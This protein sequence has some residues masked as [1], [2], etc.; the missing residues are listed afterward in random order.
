MR[1]KEYLAE[2]ER[3]DHINAHISLIQKT[4]GLTYGTD[5]F[6][7]AAFV[8][9]QKSA[10]C[11]DLGSGTGV[12]PLLLA[13]SGKIARASAVE[14]QPDF[15]ELIGRNAT[16]NH[17]DDRVLPL[18]ADIRQLHPETL[19]TTDEKKSQVDIVTTNPPYMKVNAGRRNRDDAKYL[20]RH[21]VCG[22]IG[23]FCSCAARILRSGG[24]FYCVYRPDRLGALISAMSANRLEPKRMV[25]VHADEESEPSCVLIEARLDG[26]P[27]LKML[28]PLLLHAKESRG[29]P[30]RPLTERAQKIYDTLTWYDQ[31]EV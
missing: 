12:I 15:A 6:L 4:N 14:I 8:R 21:E 1:S 5:A 28:P 13:S 7:L 9:Q 20:A 23:D 3:L 16:I 24:A 26:A 25:M 19:P 11:A 10:I 30:H 18:C 2:C 22:D 31:E 27:S 17:L 29:L